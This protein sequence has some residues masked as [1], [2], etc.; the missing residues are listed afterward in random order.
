MSAVTAAVFLSEYPEFSPAF[1]ADRIQSLLDLCE[2][3]H[4]PS[5]VWD[6]PIRQELAIKLRTAHYLECQRQQ[7]AET[8]SIGASVSQGQ[9][10]TAE[11]GDFDDLNQTVYGRQF[12]QLRKML[13]VA[14]FA[15]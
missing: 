14:G 5:S 8:A 10:A 9:Q 12:K 1:S 6:D 4:C 7:Q 11:S 3:V 2:N 15:F 13:I